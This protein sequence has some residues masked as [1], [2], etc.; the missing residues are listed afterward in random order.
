MQDKGI[1]ERSNIMGNRSGNA[2]RADGET[3]C[4]DVGQSQATGPGKDLLLVGEDLHIM[5]EQMRRAVENSDEQA[6]VHLARRQVEAGAGAL[7][8]NVGQSKKITGRMAWMVETI[9]GAVDVPL[10]LSSQV[11]KQTQALTVHK[12]RPTINAVTASPAELAGAMEVARFFNANLVVLL[13]SPML[14][15]VDVNGRLRLA[16]QVLETADRMGM[17]LE[18]LYLDPVIN[19]RPDPMLWDLSGGLPD[20]DTL[21]ES[22]RFIGALDSRVR[23]IVALS[24]SSICLSAGKRSA[25]HC[26]LLPLLAEAGLDA[27]IMN[28]MDARL[29]SVARNLRG[30]LE[31]AA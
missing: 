15:P 27:V 1:A 23:T 26:R 18:H 9:Q 25:F 19:C 17:P 31:A 21:V 22:I 14:T 3:V 5:N 29:V 7:D 16:V 4:L 11:L 6:L 28:C 10:F 30:G 13:V 8:L 20:I 2:T 12:G 24:N